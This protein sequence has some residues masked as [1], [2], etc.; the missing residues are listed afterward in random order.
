MGP[1]A[2]R[3]SPEIG[4]YSWLGRL[5]RLGLLPVK[6]VTAKRSDEARLFFMSTEVDRSGLSQLE[7]MRTELPTE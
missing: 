1:E 3:P 4:F 2:S 6:F 5:S 7:I